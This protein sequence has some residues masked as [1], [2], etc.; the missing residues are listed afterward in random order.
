M[1]GPDPVLRSWSWAPEGDWAER[2]VGPRDEVGALVA[3][4]RALQNREPLASRVRPSAW[5]LEPG[6]GP[7]ACRKETWAWQPPSLRC[8]PAAGADQHRAR[9]VIPSLSDAERPHFQG[10]KLTPAF[11][12]ELC[13]DAARSGCKARGADGRLPPV[14]PGPGDRGCRRM[15][16][17]ARGREP[18][19]IWPLPVLPS[20]VHKS[21]CRSS[22]Q[23]EE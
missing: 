14:H 17:N 15:P 6:S 12:P 3:A 13:E 18:R 7:P 1:L 8:V 20:V 16:G 4:T 11:R 5:W 22:P 10:C 21:C 19:D 9:G 23:P 2:R